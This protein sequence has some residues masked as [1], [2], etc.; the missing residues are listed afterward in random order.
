MAYLW[1]KSPGYVA[2]VRIR[3]LQR[4]NAQRTQMRSSM[5][6]T[7]NLS[8]LSLNC[9]TEPITLK[10]AELWTLLKRNWRL[11]PCDFITTVITPK[12]MIIHTQDSQSNMTSCK[13][14]FIYLTT[15]LYLLKMVYYRNNPTGNNVFIIALVQVN[16]LNAW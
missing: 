15:S 14:T 12:L 1:S 9:N 8:P 13:V 10:T 7:V 5:M 4:E 16:F 11:L 3:F 6:S 2:D